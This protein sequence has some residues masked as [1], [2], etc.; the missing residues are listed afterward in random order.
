MTKEEEIEESI[1]FCNDI[2]VYF[3][4]REKLSGSLKQGRSADKYQTE[5]S[6]SGAVMRP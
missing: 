6:S 3:E 1:E 4:K 2:Y 5:E